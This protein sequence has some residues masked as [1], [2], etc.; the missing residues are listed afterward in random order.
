MITSKALP[1][2]VIMLFLAIAAL[3]QRTTADIVGNVIDSA[4]NPVA[5]A[6]VT[7]TNVGTTASRSITTNSSSAF[8]IVNL[9]PGVYD[10]TAEA[11][12]FSKSIVKGLEL[13]VGSDMSINVE[14]KP[15]QI[16]EVVEVTAEGTL[17]QTTRSEIAHGAV[18]L[19]P[20]IQETESRS[21]LK[22]SSFLRNLARPGWMSVIG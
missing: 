16:T 18:S 6:T 8:R 12:S 13:N 2:F 17:I 22:G 21:H 7:A 4:G 19:L 20:R 9:P 3:A 1:T 10:I 14:I 11:Q 5:G 15:D